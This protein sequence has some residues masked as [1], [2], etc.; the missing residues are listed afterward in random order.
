MN[1]S[2]AELPRLWRRVAPSCR[3]QLVRRARGHAWADG[4]A[5]LRIRSGDLGA[6]RAAWETWAG[7]R[8]SGR[9][10]GEL[11]LSREDRTAA[12]ALRCMCLWRQ[13]AQSSRRRRRGSAVP[14]A[15]FSGFA[16][17]DAMILPLVWQAWAHLRTSRERSM[18]RAEADAREQRSQLALLR[19]F[20]VKHAVP[21][22]A[23]WDAW[24]SVQER[25]RRGRSSAARLRQAAERQTEADA[26]GAFLSWKHEVRE[27]A[28]LASSV[29]QVDERAQRSAGVIVHPFSRGALYFVCFDPMRSSRFFHW[30][31]WIR[32]LKLSRA[33]RSS[34]KNNKEERG[35]DL[36]TG[37][38]E[39]RGPPAAG[40]D[41]LEGRRG[42]VNMG[43][44]L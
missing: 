37:R 33:I 21:V 31:P 24:L 41:G 43:I 17:A 22:R 3:A 14:A 11:L 13:E 30:C 9:V 6:V 7:R 34:E 20:E 25:M 32:A 36:C 1:E 26:Q 15:L 39:Q 28:W 12:L 2:L 10:L 8:R 4:V 18:L 19:F 16:Q 35:S 29:R 5:A 27:R 44:L 40:A 38:E 23:V 42:G